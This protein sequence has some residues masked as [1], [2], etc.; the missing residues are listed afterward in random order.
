[1]APLL[2]AILHPHGIPHRK[3]KGG[4]LALIAAITRPTGVLVPGPFIVGQL[5]RRP[6]AFV[7]QPQLIVATFVGDKDNHIRRGR[8]ARIPGV[9]D[10]KAGEALLAAIDP[11]AI[12][13]LLLAAAAAL[14]KGLVAPVGGVGFAVARPVVKF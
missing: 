9:A 13:D 2:I 14:D 11:I 6:F 12:E 10:A 8:P 4:Q 5:H 1:M 3:G 7:H